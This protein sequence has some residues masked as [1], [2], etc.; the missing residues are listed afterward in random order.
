VDYG[1]PVPPWIGP[2]SSP[3]WFCP[4][5]PFALVD[6]LPGSQP[7]LPFPRPALHFCFS[8]GG[9]GHGSQATAGAART[10]RAAA[11][12]TQAM[13]SLL[14]KNLLKAPSGLPLHGIAR[15]FHLGLPNRHAKG[16]RHVMLPARNTQNAGFTRLNSGYKI[17][18]P[19]LLAR[20]LDDFLVSRPVV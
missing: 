13:D 3:P 4:V 7:S 19:L 2:P 20:P 17:D 14:R 12:V 11:A 9:G 15:P 6:E 10:P 1:A 16:Y 18:V 8:V 5:L